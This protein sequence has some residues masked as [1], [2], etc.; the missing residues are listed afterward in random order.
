[1]F[2]SQ[3]FTIIIDLG[4]KVTKI[5]IS[6]EPESRKIISTPELFH[7]DKYLNFQN[8]FKNIFFYK[9]TYEEI[10][11]K[12]EEFIDYIIVYILQFKKNQQ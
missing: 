9:K 11:L 8:Q 2:N 6:K 5:G 1:M 3:N 4:L 10:K 7:K 12:I